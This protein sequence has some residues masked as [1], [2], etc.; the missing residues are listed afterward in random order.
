MADGCRRNRRDHRRSPPREFPLARKPARTEQP[1][2]SALSAVS[3]IRASRELGAI[4]MGGQVINR[5]SAAANTLE[6]VT[7]FATRRAGA[8]HYRVPMLPHHYWPKA[9]CTV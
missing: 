3:G 5:P 6:I 4:N 8:V 1:S 2:A 9:R 7:E